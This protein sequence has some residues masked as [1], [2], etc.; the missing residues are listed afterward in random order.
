M[1]G[2][3]ELI[4]GGMYCGKSDELM[5]RLKRARIAGKKYQLFKPK[6]D[7]RYSNSCVITHDIN[8]K[9]KELCGIL[10]DI[11]DNKKDV[12]FENIIKSLSLAIKATSVKDSNEILKKID[13]DVKIVGIDEIQFFDKNIINVVDELKKRGK[14]VIMAGLDMYSSGEPWAITQYFA[15]T[16]KYVDKLHAVCVDCG[17]DASYSFN[18]EDTSNNFNS[19]VVVGS[20]GK[21]I[22]LC[23]NCLSER[24]K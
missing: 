23:E 19:N 20:K 22:A 15:C 21:Y 16:S 6:I 12:V 1:I 9:R 5:R 24:K 14:I 2:W 18:I 3:S 17:K 10:E 8:D 4:Y 13:N 11:K 7:N